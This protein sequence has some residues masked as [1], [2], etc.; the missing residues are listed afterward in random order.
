MAEDFLDRARRKRELAGRMRQMAPR[1]ARAADRTNILHH[2]R[3]LDAEADRLEAEAT[4]QST[5][6]RLRSGFRP[7]IIAASIVAVSLVVVQLA[8]MVLE[9]ASL[10]SRV[11]AD[12]RAQPQPELQQPGPNPAKPLFARTAIRLTS[13]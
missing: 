12:E 8:S 2:A 13:R 1:L 5:G 10:R 6:Q 3:D 9:R 7:L 11:A 4:A